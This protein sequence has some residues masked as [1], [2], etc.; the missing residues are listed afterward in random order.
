MLASIDT[1]TIPDA[2]KK[3][4]YL[5]YVARRIVA[6]TNTPYRKM[7]NI[8]YRKGHNSVVPLRYL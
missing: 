6:I 1:A 2:S 5:F 3:Y 4:T 7:H 8:I